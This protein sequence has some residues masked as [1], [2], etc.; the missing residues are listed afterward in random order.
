MPEKENQE[1][2]EKPILKK[3]ARVSKIPKDLPLNDKADA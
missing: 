2:L 1:D 3:R